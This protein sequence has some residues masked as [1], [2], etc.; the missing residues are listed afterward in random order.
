MSE[1][2]VFV[3]KVCYI[4]RQP[5]EQVKR[6]RPRLTCSDAC[7]QARYRFMKG[8]N[9][10]RSN[11]VKKQVQARRSKPF[12]ERS[13]DRQFFEPVLELSYKR[14]IYECM[15][16]GKPY[17][18]ERIWSGAKVHP[19]CSQACEEKSRYHWER[20]EQAMAKSHL[21]KTRI[22][23]RVFERFDYMKLSPLCPRCGKPFAPN[24]T[25]HGKRKRGRPRKYCSD[26]CRFEAYERR[27][28]T[29]NGRARVAAADASLARELESDIPAPGGSGKVEAEGR[30]EDRDAA[31]G[32]G[33]ADC[34]HGGEEE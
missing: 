4:C 26:A 20:F 25:I 16:C 19:Y 22:D 12:T 15:T 11:R 6:G 13:F 17:L 34:D 18:V 7:R 27:W 28:K 3:M 30:R 14:W 31:R 1:R 10:R 2:R 9:S 21:Y 33:A 29:K 8:K 5:I 32:G 23:P 24:T